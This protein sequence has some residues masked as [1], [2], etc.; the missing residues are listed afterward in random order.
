MITLRPN[1]GN[2]N[3]SEDK[4]SSITVVSTF[5]VVQSIPFLQNDKVSL[6]RFRKLENMMYDDSEKYIQ[7]SNF[8]DET[9]LLFKEVANES[10][11]PLFEHLLNTALDFKNRKSIDEKYNKGTY[12]VES[13]RRVG[14]TFINSELVTAPQENIGVKVQTLL[15]YI[16]WLEDVKKTLLKVVSSKKNNFGSNLESFFKS[17]SEYKTIMEIL[18]EQDLIQPNTYIWKDRKS[19]AKGFLVGLIKYLHLQGYYKREPTHKE[20]VLICANTFDLKLGIDTV[21]RKH[22]SD[23]DYAFIPLASTLD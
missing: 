21:K 22:G 10:R 8:K 23:F 19:G 13:N 20:I 17:I 3:I 4:L 15:D 1:K 18:V 11:E 12:K 16:K 6:Q 7:I 9:K 5:R 14:N 2:E